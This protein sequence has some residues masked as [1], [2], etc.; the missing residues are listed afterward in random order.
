M[1][2]HEKPKFVAKADPLSSIRNNKLIAQGEELEISAKSRVFVSN[3]SSP[4]LKRRYTRFFFFVYFAAFTAASSH[5][6][7]FAVHVGVLH[8]FK[9]I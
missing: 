5:S 1:N 8:V 7:F 2:E 4:R 6:F 3:I 9:E